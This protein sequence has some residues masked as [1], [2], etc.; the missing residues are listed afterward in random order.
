MRC[1]AVIHLTIDGV[2]KGSF[3]CPREEHTGPHALPP[4]FYEKYPGCDFRSL[5]AD[6]MLSEEDLKKLT[7]GNLVDPW[8]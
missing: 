6:K 3:R 8:P 1:E 5:Y 4:E 2:I 7:G